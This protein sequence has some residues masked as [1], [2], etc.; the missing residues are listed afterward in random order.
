MHAAIVAVHIF[1]RDSEELEHDG[2]ADGEE[3]GLEGGFWGEEEGSDDDTGFASYTQRE[4]PARFN[5]QI[6][7]LRMIM[8]VYKFPVEEPF[9]KEGTYGRDKI[10]VNGRV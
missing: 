2:M 10:H 8:S 3:F 5:Q 7:T 4:D 9:F 6:A 1:D